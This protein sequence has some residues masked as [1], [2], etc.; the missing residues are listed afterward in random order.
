M[1]GRMGDF[2]HQGWNQKRNH[3]WEWQRESHKSW[4]QW[5]GN[6]TQWL[7]QG[8]RLCQIGYSLILLGIYWHVQRFQLKPHLIGW[9]EYGIVRSLL[10]GGDDHSQ[11]RSYHWKP[12]LLCEYISKVDGV[13]EIIGKLEVQVH[14]RHACPGFQRLQRHWR[15]PGG[16]NKSLY[17]PGDE[18]SNGNGE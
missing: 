13:A 11:M 15:P 3:I 2:Q 9:R 17:I 14:L 5:Q 7:E 10:C 8:R 12:Q 18:H 6:L 16:Q 4:Q 1:V